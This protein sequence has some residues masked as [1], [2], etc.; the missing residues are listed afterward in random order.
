MCE[1]LLPNISRERYEADRGLPLS[2]MPELEALDICGSLLYGKDVWHRP[3]ADGLGI[4]EKSVR[5]WV[6]KGAPIPPGIW[7]E[8]R[9]LLIAHS[10][11]ARDLAAQLPSERKSA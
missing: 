4:S 1:P 5:R 8:I 9:A 7:P 6:H 2:K 10:L 11:A 3:L